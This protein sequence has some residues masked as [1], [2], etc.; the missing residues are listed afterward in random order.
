MIL[1]YGYVYDLHEKI[2]Y[3]SK[4]NDMQTISVVQAYLRNCL[5]SNKNAPKKENWINF[6]IK[7]ERYGIDV[8]EL[9]ENI[10]EVIDSLRNL[11]GFEIEL[12]AGVQEL[13]TN[14]DF[15]IGSREI[16]GCRDLFYVFGNS[17]DTN[18]KYAKAVFDPFAKYKMDGLSLEYINEGKFYRNGFEACEIP[19][20][21]ADWNYSY[22]D[23]NDYVHFEVDFDFEKYPKVL[24]KMLAVIKYHIPKKDYK[25]MLKLF[26]EEKIIEVEFAHLYPRN[27]RGMVMF[28]NHVNRVVSKISKED[29]LV[30]SVGDSSD[31][32]FL[33]WKKFE[34]AYMRVTGDGRK[35]KTAFVKC[36][37]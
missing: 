17:D 14:V 34:G 11:N 18:I 16:T 25:S 4:P 29:R 35:I 37:I 6:S 1:T 3:T 12:F 23:E 13:E 26:R 2:I 15:F 24:E 19:L 28:A 33:D 8:N 10:F 27:F 7:S 31:Y 20:D 9:S 5:S 36:E 30:L 32:I 21:K 22:S